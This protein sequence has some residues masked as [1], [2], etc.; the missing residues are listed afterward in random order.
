MT[1][2]LPL[3]C[4]TMIC[5]APVMAGVISLRGAD[6][7]ASCMDAA[8]AEQLL[9]SQPASPIEQMLETGTLLFTDSTLAGQV[10]Q[11][12]YQCRGGLPGVVYGYS[13]TVATADEAR[14]Q[15]LYKAAK[16]A[17]IARIG[18]PQL[19][20]DKLKGTDKTSFDNVPD[21]PRALSSW[22]AASSYLVH[23]SLQKSTSSDQWTIV[24]SLRQQPPDP[25]PK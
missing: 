6:V 3:T 10:T 7:G 14:A 15:N 22:D 21:G 13:I 24:T 17:V 1:L 19:D 8:S 23:V 12:L 2:K 18:S 5:T 20:S 9:G 4:L 25:T 16:S 11:V